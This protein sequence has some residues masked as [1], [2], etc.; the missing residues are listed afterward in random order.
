[1]SADTELLTKLQREIEDMNIANCIVDGESQTETR[2]AQ[3]K[4][5]EAVNAE[6]L[7]L[8]GKFAK[9]FLTLRSEHLEYNQFVD[10]IEDAGGNVSSL[11][12]TP[13]GLSD[14]RDSSGSY[15]FGLREFVEAGFLPESAAPKAI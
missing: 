11:R 14:P 15:V 7:R 8:G 13:S 9:A 3:N 12:L 5:R 10:E 4:Q 1:M 6:L 2:L